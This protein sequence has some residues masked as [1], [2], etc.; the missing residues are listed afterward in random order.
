MYAGR[1]SG[2]SALH[3]FFHRNAVD[4]GAVLKAATRSLFAAG[5]T[6]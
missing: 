1:R 6:P 4:H 5:G 2:R 3:L